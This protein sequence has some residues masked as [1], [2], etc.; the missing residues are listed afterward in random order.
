MATA[1][2]HARK[3]VESGASVW[4]H[5]SE[6]ERARMLDEDS[7]ALSIVSA[8]LVSIVCLGFVLIAITLGAILWG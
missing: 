3:P 6:A 4:N 7:L 8:E 1:N 5:F 2:L